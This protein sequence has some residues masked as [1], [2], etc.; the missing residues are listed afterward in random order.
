MKKILVLLFSILISFNSYG[1]WKLASTSDTADTYIDF[2]NIK[3]NNGY[4]YYWNLIVLKEPNP[5]GD[6][7]AKVLYEVDC[8]IPQKERGISYTYYKLPMGQGS[9]SGNSKNVGDWNYSIPGS[10][11]ETTFGL[12]CGY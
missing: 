4:V 12:V 3:E 9:S 10:M 1:E 6:L 5:R 8:R 11:R 2:D 7:S